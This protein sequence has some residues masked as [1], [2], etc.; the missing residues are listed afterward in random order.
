MHLKFSAD[1]FLGA[2]GKSFYIYKLEISGVGRGGEGGGGLS[3]NFLFKRCWGIMSFFIDK[4][5][6][7][8]LETN[9]MLFLSL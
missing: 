4:G 7:R 5:I 1:F 8:K 2:G 6:L 9:L 3:H